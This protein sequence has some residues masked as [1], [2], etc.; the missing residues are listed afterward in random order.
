MTVICRLSA[1]WGFAL[2]L[3]SSGRYQNQVLPTGTRGT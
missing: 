3:A 1:D 2:Y